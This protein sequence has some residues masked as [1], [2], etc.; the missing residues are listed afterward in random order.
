MRGNLGST[1]PSSMS[2][3]MLDGEHQR[4]QWKKSSKVTDPSVDSESEVPTEDGKWLISA[5]K[6]LKNCEHWN[7]PPNR[8]NTRV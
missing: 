5:N 2:A 6:L 1:N 8:E 3:N 7:N 4:C